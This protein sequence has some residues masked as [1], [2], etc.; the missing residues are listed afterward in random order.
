MDATHAI[1]IAKGLLL[2]QPPGIPDA[3]L[4]EGS[5]TDDGWCWVID[6]TSRRTLES[7]DP[8][9][10]PLP[11]VG[12]IAVNKTDGEAFYLSSVTLPIALDVAK[13]ARGRRVRLTHQSASGS[14][15]D[16][17]GLPPVVTRSAPG[18]SSCESKPLSRTPG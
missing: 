4:I 17:T 2:R 15:R 1:E 8:A 9:D 11:G 18:A 6:W 16:S 10:A 3:D 14:G 12:P 5:A 13:Q 7:H